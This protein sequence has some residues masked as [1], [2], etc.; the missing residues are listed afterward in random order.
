MRGVLS[1]DG[2]F[3]LQPGG[4]VYELNKSGWIRRKDIEIKNKQ[5]FIRSR[6][7]E[8]TDDLGGK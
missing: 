4:R 8:E 2:K 6:W 1:K 7:G 3:I 5:Q